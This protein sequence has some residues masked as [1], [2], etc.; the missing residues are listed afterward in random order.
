MDK[1]VIHGG[2]KLRGE[3]VIS[4]SKN[5]ALPILF[6]TLLTDESITINN[7]ILF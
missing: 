6:A 2:N 1:I 7:T 5:S 3:V 4:G